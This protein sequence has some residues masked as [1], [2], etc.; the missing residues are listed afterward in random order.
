MNGLSWETHY[1]IITV[2]VRQK[3]YF[4]FISHNCFVIIYCFNASVSKV[5]DK[6][7]HQET[8]SAKTALIFLIG[9]ERFHF[10]ILV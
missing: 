2:L 10:I 1:V 4:S 9:L 5:A 8:V 7:T 6:T 3:E